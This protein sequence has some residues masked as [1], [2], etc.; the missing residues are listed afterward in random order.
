MK[1]FGIIYK[2]TNN[3]NGKVY[4][5]QT[6]QKFNCR[7]TRHRF[8]SKHSDIGIFCRATR[9]YG[10]ENFDW[11]ILE[12]CDSKEEM[13][14]MEFHYIKQYNSLT[15]D[16]YNLTLGGEGSLGCKPSLDSRLKMKK[17]SLG[18]KHTEE[19]KKRITGKGN[20]FYGKKHS[21]AAKEKMRGV[22]KHLCK[23]YVIIYPDGEEVVIV[24]LADFANKHNI[25]ITNLHA[26]AKN[27]RKHAKGY[28]CRY[29]CETDQNLS[30]W[31]G[32]V[33]WL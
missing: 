16:G 26:C 14:D 27:K 24:G 9:K 29:Y 18:F 12:Y 20:Y 11:T 6:I 21:K 5:G 22:R 4:I 23:K 8:D 3:I 28:K 2:A 31:E 30:M 33:E 17:S 13:N 15:P 10:F 7:I 32:A 19:Y 25:C 1:S